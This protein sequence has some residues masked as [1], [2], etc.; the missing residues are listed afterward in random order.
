[1]KYQMFKHTG[2]KITTYYPNKI[3]K[4][5]HPSCETSFFINFQQ[6]VRISQLELNFCETSAAKTAPRHQNSLSIRICRKYEPGLMLDFLIQANK[7]Y[8]FL[9][10][11]MVSNEKRD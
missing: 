6:I 11:E 8:Q 5:I 1:M 9:I 4:F 3:V 7:S 10:S 2:N